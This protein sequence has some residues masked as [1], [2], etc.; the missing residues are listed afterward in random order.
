MDKVQKTAFTDCEVQRTTLLLA[1]S[2]TSIMN[3]M[4]VSS[5][6]LIEATL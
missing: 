2:L 4:M 6:L 1:I 3:I 5:V